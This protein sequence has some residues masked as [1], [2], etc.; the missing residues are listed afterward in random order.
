E[1][2]GLEVAVA[3]PDVFGAIE[4][5]L[6]SG[7]WF[8]E[9]TRKLPVTVLGRTA[10]DR[11]GIAQPGDRVTIDGQWYGGLGIL[12]SAGLATDIDTAAI[13]CDKWVRDTFDGASIGEGSAIYVRVAPG[14]IS[15]VMDIL[16]TAASAGAPFLS[17]RAATVPRWVRFQR[18]TSDQHRARSVR[19]WTCLRR[20]RALAHRSCPSGRSR[21][22]LTPIPLP[23]TRCRPSAS[24]SAGLHCWSARSVSPTLW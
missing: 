11:L 18:N 14:Q 20:Q 17:D 7:R 5:E 9:A 22:S 1:T 13:L 3:R 4:A 21:N 2:N 6:A 8:D 12:E 15:Q 19:S 24:H 23:T 16:A 10:A